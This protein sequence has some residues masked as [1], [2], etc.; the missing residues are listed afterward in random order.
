M[1]LPHKPKIMIGVPGFGGVV[2]QCQENFFGFAF[3]LGRDMPEYEFLLRIVIKKEQFRARNNLIDMAIA[4]GCDYLLMLDDDMLIPSDLLSRLLEH[5]KDVIGALYWQRS[6]AHHPVVLY[7]DP[8]PSGDLGIKFAS[9]FANIMTKRGLYQ[10]DIIGGGCMLFKMHVFDKLK[11]PYFWWEA[12]EG[13]DIAICRSLR[14]LGYEIWVDTSIELGHLG[15]PQIITSR[16]VPQY[17]A[18]MGRIREDLFRDVAN[19]LE[20]PDEAVKSAIIQA[21]EKASRQEHWGD[22]D[23]NDWAQVLDYYQ[24]G[25]AWHIL[26][27]TGFQLSSE[28]RAR[29]FVFTEFD[30]VLPRGSVVLDYGCGVGTCALELANQGYDVLALDLQGVPTMDFV[31]W[32]L[33]H[34]DLPGSV[35][36]MTIDAPLPA[37]PLGETLDGALMISVLDHLPYPYETLQW[38]ISHLRKGGA[39]VCDWEMMKDEGEHQHLMQYDPHTFQHWMRDQGMECTPEKPWLFIKQGAA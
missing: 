26:N 23:G 25:D 14:E 11:N 13:T 6:G 19:Y 21:T 37:M 35:R 4:N 3:R 27:L 39:L 30:R 38:V 20:L 18:E 31:R 2:P 1:S 7:D 29:R 34:H 24:S 17:S 12:H 10:V 32:R 8:K 15:E 36:T 16:T 33:E 22:R 5:D 9:P 28:N